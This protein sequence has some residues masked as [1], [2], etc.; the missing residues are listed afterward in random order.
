MPDVL[1]AHIIVDFV[2]FQCP[3]RLFQKVSLVLQLYHPQE[4]GLVDR[5]NVS[6]DVEKPERDDDEYV[7]TR[8]LSAL[9]S[10]PEASRVLSRKGSVAWVQS[11]EPCPGLRMAPDEAWQWG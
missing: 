4:F 5:A 10:Q 1:L 6:Y 11:R 2:P 7:G 3:D 9:R 8:R